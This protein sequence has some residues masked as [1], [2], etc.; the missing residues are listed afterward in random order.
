MAEI[1]SRYKVA[2]HRD[3]VEAYLRNEKVYPACLELDLTAACNRNCPLCP[4][5]GSLASYSLDLPLIES[6]F[7]ALEGQTQGLLLTGGEP[8]MAP[9]FGPALAQARARGFREIAVVTNGT[10]LNR[11]AVMEALLRH[12]SVVRISLYDW[13]ADSGGGAASILGHVEALRRHVDHEGS[14]LQIGVSVLTTAENASGLASI[15]R[16]ACEAGAHWIY[17]HP[18]CMHWDIGAPTRVSQGRVLQTVR[19]LQRAVRDGFQ[20]LTCPERYEESKVEFHGY[21]G[22]HFLLVIGA[23][24]ICYLGA[25]V[26]YQPHYAV[27]DLR[28]ARIPDF[29]WSDQRRA[30]ILSVES[31]AYPPLGSR[32]RGALYS[33]LLQ[34]FMSGRL[35]FDRLA[36][37]TE[38]D[39]FLYPHIL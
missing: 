17:F 31:T 7:A 20:V 24:G 25:E 32:H 12:V 15:T 9:I 5:S 2:F 26:K 21:H 3:K 14:A 35:S 38:K 16:Q 13:T 34:G 36:W 11:P 10:L 27:S 33:D 18:T 28:E 8:T 4:S 37:A 1:A 29:L 39:A 22:A 23:D 19:E 6:L 30:W